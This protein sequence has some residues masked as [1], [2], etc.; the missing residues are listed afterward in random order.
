MNILP[1]CVPRVCLVPREVRTVCQILELELWMI[2][3]HRVWVLGSQT[4]I[5]AG[6]TNAPSLSSSPLGSPYQHIS[7]QSLDRS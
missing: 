3:S 2:E 6:A 5:S 7:S 4:L 1:P